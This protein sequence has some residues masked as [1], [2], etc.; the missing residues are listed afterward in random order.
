[1]VLKVFQIYRGDVG[2]VQGMSQLGFIIYHVF[3]DE[4]LTFEYF[5]FLILKKY[6]LFEFFSF[7]NKTVSRFSK[8]VS[9]FCKSNVKD[10][11]ETVSFFL[12]N[13][14]GTY[15]YSVF[16][17]CFVGFFEESDI[18]LILDLF[19]VQNFHVLTFL[20][21]VVVIL[22]SREKP[23]NFNLSNLKAFTKKKGLESVF[24]EAARLSFK[25]EDLVKYWESEN[26]EDL[27]G[28]TES[29]ESF[30]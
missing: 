2:Y 26:D 22:Y 6:P 3:N 18:F 7:D 21:I 15:L 1:M 8:C 30:R 23:Q 25:L 16:F 14:V 27:G 5:V 4:F 19:A 28:L 12:E 24:R 17:T 29:D 11:S 20:S 9:H 13:M 10:P